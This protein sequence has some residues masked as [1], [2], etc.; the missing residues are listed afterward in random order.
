LVQVSQFSLQFSEVVA[1]CVIASSGQL[2]GK[3]VAIAGKLPS[4]S[5]DARL[6]GGIVVIDVDAAADAT[7]EIEGAAANGLDTVV[8]SVLSSPGP[9][10]GGGASPKGGPPG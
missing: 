10:W 3:A 7:T 9:F 6:A 2:S 8:E 1:S 5:K 4:D